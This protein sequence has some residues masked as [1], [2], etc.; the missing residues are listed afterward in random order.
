MKRTLLPCR[1]SR[2]I[3]LISLVGPLLCACPSELSI[4]DASGTACVEHSDC[5][6][7]DIRCGVL[8]A[9]VF[10]HCS[11]EPTLF[12]PCDDAGILI[13]AALADGD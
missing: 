7:S 4:P 11:A 6:P 10:E 2:L 1:P 9:C 13:D 5:N 8:H 12:V 3:G